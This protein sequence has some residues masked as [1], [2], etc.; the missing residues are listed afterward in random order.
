LIEAFKVSTEKGEMMPA[1]A[2]QYPVNGR[3]V[4]GLRPA[5]GKSLYVIRI[6]GHGIV[7]LMMEVLTHGGIISLI[8]VATRF[9]LQ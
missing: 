3:M 8:I 4:L 1:S 6:G 5:W 9:S 7:F 2:L